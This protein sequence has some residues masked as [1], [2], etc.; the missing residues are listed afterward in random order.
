MKIKVIVQKDNKILIERYFK[1]DQLIDYIVCEDY[2]FESNTYKNGILHFKLQEALK[3]FNLLVNDYDLYIKKYKTI[4]N[5]EKKK[6]EK[7][8]KKIENINETKINNK[9]NIDNSHEPN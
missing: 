4:I 6:I 8:L 1:E 7:E 9:I 3:D 5:K 2:E